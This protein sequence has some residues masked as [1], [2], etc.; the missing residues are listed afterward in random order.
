MAWVMDPFAQT[1]WYTHAEEGLGGVV[2]TLA[3]TGTGG[4]VRTNKA[5]LLRVEEG[6]SEGGRRVSE[7]SEGGA[8]G[9]AGRGDKEH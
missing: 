5:I 9:G 4:P 6:A 7:G 3:V 8:G 2:H 1:Y